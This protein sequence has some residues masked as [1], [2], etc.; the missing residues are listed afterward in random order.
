MKSEEKEISY[1]TT[2]SYSTLNTLKSSTK[3]VWFVCHGLG[4]LS[5]YFLKYFKHL[6]TDENYI[7]APQ[8]PSKYYVKQDFKYVGASW[9]T[10][11]NT[12][13]ESKNILNYFDSILQKENIPSN[14]NIIVFGYSQGVSV[15][16]RYVAFKQ[17]QCHKLILHSGSIPKELNENDFNF[18]NG[19]THVVCGDKDEYITPNRL[20]TELKRAHTL[21]KN[22]LKVELFDGKHEVNINIIKALAQ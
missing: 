8:A 21:F 2:N 15:A 9:L 4:Y 11:E 14:V 16:T 13:T 10:K 7:I 12:T 18:Y 6:N 20:Q 17:L 22:N 1:T 5:R 19:Q 3:N